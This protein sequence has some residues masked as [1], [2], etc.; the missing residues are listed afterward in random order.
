MTEGEPIKNAK[1]KMRE[2]DLVTRLFSVR[3][4]AFSPDNCELRTDN[5]STRLIICGLLLAACSMQVSLCLLPSPVL[6]FIVPL[7]FP[8]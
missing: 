8:A 3:R 6:D 5:L 7:A 2:V 4:T 1:C